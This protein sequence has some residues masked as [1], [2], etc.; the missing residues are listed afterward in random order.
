MLNGTTRRPKVCGFTV[1]V[2]ECLQLLG[3]K[4]RIREFWDFGMNAIHSLGHSTQPGL[5]WSSMHGEADLSHFPRSGSDRV[6]N[7][8]KARTTRGDPSRVCSHHSRHTRQECRG[9]WVRRSAN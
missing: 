2:L 8:G 3:S 7:R 9:R 4:L 5:R 1:T 6:R